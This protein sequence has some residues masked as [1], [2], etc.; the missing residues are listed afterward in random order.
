MYRRSTKK[1]TNWEKFTVHRGGGKEVSLKVRCSYVNVDR[2]REGQHCCTF[3]K[4]PPN[5]SHWE[6]ALTGVIGS[7]KVVPSAEAL[8]DPC[9]RSQTSSI[10]LRSF[11]LGDWSR[12]LITSGLRSDL[13]VSKDTSIVCGLNLFLDTEVLTRSYL[14]HL[15][16]TYDRIRVRLVI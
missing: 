1:K 10:T 3:R 7:Q 15:I 5:E 8:G 4:F 13:I 16:D 9:H 12:Q 6:A 11:D 2:E 14:L